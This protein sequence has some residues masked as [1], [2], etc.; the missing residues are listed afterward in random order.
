MITKPSLNT[1]TTPFKYIT[2]F[3]FLCAILIWVCVWNLF[4]YQIEFLANKYE[5]NSQY[6]YLFT[7]IL[8][9]IGCSHLFE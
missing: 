6:L 8:L 2:K 5:F 7:L 1:N 3:N 4:E 9:L